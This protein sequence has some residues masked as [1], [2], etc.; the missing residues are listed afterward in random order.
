M[1]LTNKSLALIL[2][3]LALLFFATNY[4]KKKNPKNKLNTNLVEIQK[5]QISKIEIG[6]KNTETPIIFN[7]KSENWEVSNGKIKSN[8]KSNTFENLLNTLSKIRVERLVVKTKEKWNAYELT[9]STATKVTI[10]QQGT[11]TDLYF[12]KVKF[13]PPT[14]QYQYNPK[15]ISGST[16]FRIGDS[17]SVYI[18]EG[19][20]NTTL[21]K[22]F[23]SWRENKISNLKKDEIT[24]LKFEYKDNESFSVTKNDSIW[25]ISDQI[26]ENEKITQYL[27]K[28]AYKSNS[29]FADEFTATSSPDYKLIIERNNMEALKIES[30]KDSAKGKFYLKSSENPNAFFESDSTGVQKDFF[31]NSSYFNKA[32]L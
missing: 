19:I 9:D 5:D 31:V 7:K 29:N 21:N 12:G 20:L 28:I 10:T 25:K 22:G 13:N 16:Y 27:N 23:N 1:K 17:P 15:S 8:V 26:I 24:Q 4:F 32:K 18:T 30:Y 3:A 6:Q 11:T 14:N 2:G